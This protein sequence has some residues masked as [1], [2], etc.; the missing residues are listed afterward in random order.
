MACLCVPSLVVCSSVPVP[1]LL[2]HPQVVG[3]GD[4]VL[5]IP[6]T[7]SVRLAGAG[8][9]THAGHV[10]SLKGGLVHATKGGQLWLEGRQKR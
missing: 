5:G 1:C 9:S 8:L 7:G 4:A 2:V 6:E 3:P 10:V